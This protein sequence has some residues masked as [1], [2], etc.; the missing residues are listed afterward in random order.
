MLLYRHCV[1]QI[2]LAVF[3]ANCIIAVQALC[4]AKS[5]KL[6]CVKSCKLQ[7]R[8]CVVQIVPIV[9]SVNCIIAVQALCCAKSCKLCRAKSCKLQYWHCIIALQALYHCCAQWSVC[10]EMQARN[11][12]R[13]RNVS[14]GY[15]P[16]GIL[17]NN[18]FQ[19]A[20]N[21]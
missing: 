21:L 13:C 3:S 18:L 14:G 6:C 20:T 5:C 12:Q 19:E 10:S 9:Y 8:H 7:Y 15:S 11:V 4:C 16:K 1:V 17:L 2:V